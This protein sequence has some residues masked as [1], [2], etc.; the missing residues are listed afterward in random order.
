MMRHEYFQQYRKILRRPNI[1]IWSAIIQSVWNTMKGVRRQRIK[2]N[3]FE[4]GLTSHLYE[5]PR[6]YCSFLV[7]KWSLWSGRNHLPKWYSSAH[8]LGL[9]HSRSHALKGILGSPY[10]FRCA[11]CSNNFWC[12]RMSIARSV[13]CR[14]ERKRSVY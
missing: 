1:N 12:L 14:R 8:A 11:Q 4:I 2:E 3:N 9:S 6:F 5:L 10:Y 7:F 13:Q